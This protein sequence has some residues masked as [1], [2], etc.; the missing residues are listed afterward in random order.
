[1]N[2][3][4]NSLNVR[5]HSIYIIILFLF[6][7]C[8]C[9]S[10]KAQSS[11]MDENYRSSNFPSDT[12]YSSYYFKY[13]EINDKNKTIESALSEV[14]A[15][16]ANSI[17]SKVS[18]TSHSSASSI[19]NNSGYYESEE[20][21][22]DVIIAAQANLINIHLDYFYDE[23][24]KIVYAFAYVKKD[25]LSSY[26]NGYLSSN[27]TLLNEKIK[28]INELISQGYKVEAKN[29]F[30][31]LHPVLDGLIYNLDNFITVQPS[32]AQIAGYTRQIEEFSNIIKKFETDLS[33]SISIFIESDLQSIYRIQN[34]IS[35]KC[36]GILADHG[37][38]F[39]TNTDDADYVVRINCATRTSSVSETT[40]YAYADVDVSI[41]RI[42]DNLILYQD[43]FSEKGGALNEENAHR[44]ALNDIPKTISSKILTVISK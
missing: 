31:E 29:R 37:F 32:S 23:P 5:V 28:G 9:L 41:T 35:D 10:S 13:D 1:M 36:K 7:N 6:L 21:Y 16:L 12:Y 26:L 24:S 18:S 38:N 19:N 11:W 44:K 34:T 33:H 15:L 27:L 30:E 4:L 42:R 43:S 3:S 22:N 39:V 2:I 8:A 25:D 40:C 17:N 20:F 14:Q